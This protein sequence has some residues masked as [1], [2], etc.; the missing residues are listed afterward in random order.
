[1]KKSRIAQDVAHAWARNLHFG[2][3]NA[4]AKFVLCML[5]QYVNGEGHCFV[6]VNHLAEDCDL[7]RRSAQRYLQ[8]LEDDAKV[9]RRVPQFRDAQGHRNST[10]IGRRTTDLIVLLIDGVEEYSP[11]YDDEN[12]GCQA[13]TPPDE[14]TSLRRV[15]GSFGVTLE[16]PP[17]SLN[18]N[19]KKDAR[20]R[21]RVGT[22]ASARTSGE[23]GA[24]QWVKEGTRWWKDIAAFD[25]AHMAKV[26]KQYRYSG[27][28]PEYFGST[29]WYFLKTDVAKARRMAG[30][31][32]DDERDDEDAARDARAATG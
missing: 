23:E 24:Y 5:A 13:V 27:D 19:M 31:V 7:S 12:E 17:E 28:N 29:G 30:G 20:A 2:E 6:S 26:P 4:L 32:N 1:M 10:G 15:C 22:R 11:E 21:A 8:W 25:P 18:M 14:N 16:S 9:I 3:G